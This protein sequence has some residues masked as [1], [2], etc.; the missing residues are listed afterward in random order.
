MAERMDI[1]RCDLCGQVIE[2]FEGGAGE[3][4]CCEEPMDLMK[5]KTTDPS[6]EKH[7]PFVEQVEGGIKV[8]VGKEAAH[9]MEASHFIQWIEVVAGGKSCRKQLEPGDAP[10]AF[11]PCDGSCAADVVVRELC[12]VHGLWATS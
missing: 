3:L 4:V 11:F 9:P 10:E 8:R 1:Y 5:P 2:V 6:E 7:V 12:N